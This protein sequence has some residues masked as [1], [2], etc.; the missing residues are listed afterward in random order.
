MEFS[1]QAYW[2]G[3]PFPF[4]GNLSDPRIEPESPASPEFTGRFFTTKPPGKPYYVIQQFHSSIH[5]KKAKT[6][7]QNIHAPNDHSSIISHSQDVE[8]T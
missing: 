8:A 5:L 1:S 2:T 4:P 6:Q 7:N 3:W